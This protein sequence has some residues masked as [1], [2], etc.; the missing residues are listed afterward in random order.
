MAGKKSRALAAAEQLAGHDSA[1]GADDEAR[2]TRAMVER[3]IV[4]FDEL[5]RLPPFDEDAIARRVADFLA[6]ADR[7]ELGGVVDDAAPLARAFVERGLRW[8]AARPHLAPFTTP[9]WT[10]EM[11]EE[12]IQWF[13]HATGAALDARASAEVGRRLRTFA[14]VVS[15]GAVESG[16]AESLAEAFLAHAMHWIERHPPAKAA[17]QQEA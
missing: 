3:A 13:A 5:E 1:S 4:V 14:A 15:T 6:F 8:L 7:V 9:A 17:F 12:V 16:D 2:W 10:A 11:V